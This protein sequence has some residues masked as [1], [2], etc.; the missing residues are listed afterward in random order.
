MGRSWKSALNSYFKK[1][2]NRPDHG[3]FEYGDENINRMIEEGKD[4][5]EI[6]TVLTGDNFYTAE[7]AEKS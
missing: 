5:E 3:P 2:N 6:I 7:Q 4:V 1:D